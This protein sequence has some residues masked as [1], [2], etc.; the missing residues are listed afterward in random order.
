MLADSKYLEAWWTQTT[1][2]H[3]KEV[4]LWEALDFLIKWLVMQF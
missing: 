2:P 4:N 3:P 1:Q